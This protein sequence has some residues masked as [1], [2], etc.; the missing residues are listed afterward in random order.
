MLPTPVVGA[1]GLLDD[2]AA[3]T[4]MALPG[5]G[6]ALVLV[7][8]TRGHLGRSLWLETVEGR[9]EGPPP[10]VDLAAERRNGDFVRAEIRAG[11][12]A[13]CHDL[14][15][16]GLL[17]A[18]A[19]MA[20]AGGVG[21]TLRP[22]LDDAVAGL[23]GEDQA[24]YLLAVEDPEDVLERAA[25]AGVPASRIGGTGG[26]ALTVEGHSSISLDELRDLHE[27]WMPAWIAGG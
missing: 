22:P 20:L 1:V 27:A 10:P 18:A 13:A 23:F 5:P 15:D 26:S 9:E 14:S 7:G 4:G 17:I 21:A 25:A 6:V 3:R 8:E 12:V 16:G 19:E 2:L 24:R 11:R